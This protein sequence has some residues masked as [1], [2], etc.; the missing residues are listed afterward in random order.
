MFQA[1]IGMSTRFW[2]TKSTT[3]GHTL[4]HKLWWFGRAA[5]SKWSRVLVSRYVVRVG[6]TLHYRRRVPATIRASVGKDWWKVSLKTS[7]ER[8]AERKA[9]VFA[10]E[11]D[12]A[13]SY[14][15]GLDIKTQAI[16]LK[17]L[18]DEAR[19]RFFARAEE[20]TPL[21]AA[22]EEASIDEVNCGGREN[23]G[24]PA[25]NRAQALAR[26]LADAAIRK[27][28][29]VIL[30]AAE[31][32]YDTLP[33]DERQAV[34]A[35]GG[36]QALYQA[37]KRGQVEISSDNG[38]YSS[39]K[40]IHETV[41]ARIASEVLFEQQRL[42]AKHGVELLDG[43][44][45]PKNPRI[46]TAMEAWFAERRQGDLA[47]KRH[48]T[49]LRRL[50]SLHGDLPVRALSRAMV[51]QYRDTLETLTDHRHLPTKLRGGLE[52]RAVL[53]TISAKTVERHL[54]S[55]KALLTFCV[56][57]GWVA[58]N[59]ATGIKPPRDTRPKASKRRHFN[60]EERSQLLQRAIAEYGDQSDR[61]WIIKL[62]AYTGC[63]L[64]EVA[65]LARENVRK[66][67]GV[68]VVEINDLDG[69]HVKGSNSVRSV[70]LHPAIQKEFLAWLA[71]VSGPRVFAS[72]RQYEGRYATKLSGDMARLMD[73]AGINDSRLVMHSFRHGLK[74][75][76]ADAGIDGD[77]RRAFLGH[78]PRDTHDQ[79]QLPSTRALAAALASMPPLFSAQK[80]DIGIREPS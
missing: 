78:A 24:L 23:F 34:E 15:Q 38:L 5:K 37:V 42:L 51:A 19:R 47:I 17:S 79:Y 22:T 80:D 77:L 44:D 69:R 72:L 26:Q 18:A 63:R 66:V 8:E 29:T 28:E 60:R 45:D 50:A 55:L 1:L 48:R 4:G 10:V 3:L 39:K 58:S 14:H 76:M 40:T 6:Q 73:R 13:I 7:D 65:Q 54:I 43:R 75:A 61:V 27:V 21:I 25:L 41:K 20:V 31:Q 74:V 33:P 59:V 49:S 46:L 70:P 67:D 11:H 53:P 32:R 52:Q 35:E 2:V 12:N 30:A 68:W 62:A 71:R 16:R 57:R 9:R 64:E 56:E 36:L